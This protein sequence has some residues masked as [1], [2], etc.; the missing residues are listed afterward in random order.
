MGDRKRLHRQTVVQFRDYQTWVFQRIL[1]NIP[2]QLYA[3]IAADKK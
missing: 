1:T 2:K 3:R